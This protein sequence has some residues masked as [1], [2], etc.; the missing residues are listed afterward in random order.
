MF[1]CI[2]FA[3]L[4]AAGSVPNLAAAPAGSAAAAPVASEDEP[5]SIVKRQGYVE[6]DR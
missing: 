3:T 4:V 6:I 2:E 5:H 1:V